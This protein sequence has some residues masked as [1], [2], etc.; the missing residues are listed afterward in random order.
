MADFL[1]S[2]HCDIHEADTDR[3]V[4][5]DQPMKLLMMLR[6]LTSLLPKKRQKFSCKRALK[7]LLFQ[8]D[9]GERMSN[10]TVL[11]ELFRQ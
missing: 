6:S 11:R 5:M 2:C 9:P 7:M 4:D 3:K 1:I 8:W 10:L